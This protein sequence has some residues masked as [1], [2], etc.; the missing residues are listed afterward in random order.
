MVGNYDKYD[1]LSN[2]RIDRMKR[3]EILDEDIRPF[4]EVSPYEGQFD[5]ADYQRSSFF[6]YGGEEKTV[7]LS[8]D[9]FLLDAMVDRFGKLKILKESDDQ[10]VFEAKVRCGEGF[11]NWILRWG[12]NVVVLEPA[13]VRAAIAEKVKHLADAYDICVQ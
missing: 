13:D 7:T 4:A 12:G 6:M 10:F 3:V 2:Y 9:T 8:C 1:N 5:I 11:F